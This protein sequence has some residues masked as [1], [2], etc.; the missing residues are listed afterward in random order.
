MKIRPALASD[1]ETIADI[2]ATSWRDTYQGTLAAEY[3][4]DVVPRERYELWIDRFEKPKPNQYVAVA[5]QDGE[6]LGFACVYV[7]ENSQWGSYVDNLHVRK[8]HQSKGIG[9]SLLA[10]ICRWCLQQN[11]AGS[12][13]LTVNQDNVNAQ[14]FYK[15]VGARNLKEDMW[16][17]PDGSRVPI[18]WFV[19]DKA[20]VDI[21]A[22]AG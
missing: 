19:W 21:L 5:E 11:P 4:L 17:A 1:A 12:I 2:H 15:S 14:E 8:D 7:G 20:N 3:L 18:Y 6:I 9:K 16:N 10:E 13:C 22:E